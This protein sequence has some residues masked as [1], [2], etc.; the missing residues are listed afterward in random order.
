VSN[1]ASEVWQEHLHGSRRIFLGL[2]AAGVAVLRNGPAHGTGD[3]PMMPV[4][5]PRLQAAIPKLERWL[6]PA[7]GPFPIAGTRA[8]TRGPPA[9]PAA[10]TETRDT[11]RPIGEMI[12]AQTSWLGPTGKGRIDRGW[13]QSA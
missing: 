9:Q 3:P 7:V 1:A 2:G 13:R 8:M 4:T 5:D 6:T 10:K 11:S 12:L